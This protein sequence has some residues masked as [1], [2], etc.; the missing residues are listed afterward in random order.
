MAHFSCPQVTISCGVSYWNKDA[1]DTY[2]KLFKRADEALYIAK[3]TGKNK[4]VTQ[5]NNIK[6]S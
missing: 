6:K 4:A 3:G 5:D 2:N 1:R